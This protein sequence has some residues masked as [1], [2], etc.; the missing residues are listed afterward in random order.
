MTIIAIYCC[1]NNKAV[2]NSLSSSLSVSQGNQYD[3]TNIMSREVKKY[4]IQAIE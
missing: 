3:Q 1:R 4:E 2:I